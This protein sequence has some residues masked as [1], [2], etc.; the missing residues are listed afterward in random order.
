VVENRQFESTPIWRP[1]WGWFRWSFA[2]I[3]GIKNYRVP[4]LSYGI[5]I[6]LAIFVELQQTDRRTHHDSIYRGNIASRGENWIFTWNGVIYWIQ[7]GSFVRDVTRKMSN[8]PPEVVIWC[9]F[10]KQWIRCQSYGVDI[11]YCVLSQAILCLECWNVTKCE[12]TIF[13]GVPHSKFWGIRSSDVACIVLV[14]N[15]LVSSQT[16]PSVFE[17]LSKVLYTAAACGLLTTGFVKHRKWANFAASVGCLKGKRLSASEG[18]AH[19][20]PDHQ[21][22]APG[23]RW[24]LC[25]KTSNIRST[26]APPEILRTP[27]ADK[28]NI[29]PCLQQMTGTIAFPF[30]QMSLTS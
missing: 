13:I 26:Q 20:P 2:E 16:I 23:P 7:G 29:R 25:S 1:R 24:G 18:F 21:G 17:I 15:I 10:G 3:F 22:S 9:T 14:D 5:V 28:V 19:S 11:F 12:G 30:R 27:L 8:F 6:G 4:G